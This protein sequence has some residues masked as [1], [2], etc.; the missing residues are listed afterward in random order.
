LVAIVVVDTA[1]PAAGLE[2][3]VE[4]GA[5]RTLPVRLQGLLLACMGGAFPG[6]FLQLFR[7]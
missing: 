4:Q 3:E 5:N 6:C 1:Y 7:N 2:A